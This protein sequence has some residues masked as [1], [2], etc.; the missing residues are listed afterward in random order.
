MP[1]NLNPQNQSLS[2]YV[3]WPFCMA[4]CPDCDFNS[5][6]ATTIDTMSWQKALVTE[7]AFR[8]QKA[9]IALSVDHRNVEL[10]SLFFGGGTPSLMPPQIAADI[11]DCAASH[12]KIADDIEITA[13]MNPTSLKEKS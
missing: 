8:A 1:A 3:H 5:H 11:I 12:F 13:E 6:V 4:K 10:K 9:S 7:L 2:L